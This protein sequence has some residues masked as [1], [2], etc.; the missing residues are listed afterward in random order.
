MNLKKKIKNK[1]N[2]ITQKYLHLVYK[3]LQ[4]V[5]KQAKMNLLFWQPLLPVIGH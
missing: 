3:A 2:N 4:R 5:R 1:K